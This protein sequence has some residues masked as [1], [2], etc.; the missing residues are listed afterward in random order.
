MSNTSRHDAWQ[1]GDSY[2]RYMGR[3]SRLVAPRFLDWLGAPAA[4]DWLDVGCGTGALTAAIV[5]HCAPRSVVSIDPSA[6]FLD[7]ARG[8][9]GAHL[10]EFHLGDAQALPVTDHSKDVVVSGL[11]LNFVPDRPKALSEMQRVARQGAT[12]GFYVW[13]YPG[14]GVEFMRAFWTAAVALDAAAL[15]LK[16][17]RRFPFC[18]L[19]GLQQ[20]ATAAGLLSVAATTIEVPTLF[21]D[22]DDFWLPFTLGAG[23]AP[24]YCAGLQPEAR[25]RLRL[26]LS[27]ELPRQPDGTIAMQVRAFAVRGKA[28]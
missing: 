2:D 14:G 12:V 24:G 13:D 21:N 11:V 28:G 1:A 27:D 23:P 17:D 3:W 5:A 9:V 7:K 25:E 22:F 26:R 18:T 6:G 4:K 10:A 16:E 20:L 15:D 19:D 8:T